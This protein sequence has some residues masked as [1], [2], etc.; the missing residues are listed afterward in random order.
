MV[1]VV[2]F[3]IY[4][5][6]V[7]LHI[8]L[9]SFEMICTVVLCALKSKLISFTSTYILRTHGSELDPTWTR[10]M[11]RH[12]WL[13]VCLASG[14]LKQHKAAK[15]KGG[16]GWTFTARAVRTHLSCCVVA[17]VSEL[18]CV[19]VRERER[20]RLCREP[21]EGMRT[22]KKEEREIG[23]AIYMP[24]Y[25]VNVKLLTSL[26]LFFVSFDLFMELILLL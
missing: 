20:E 18:M 19:C 8:I 25:Y 21:K 4:L 12:W 2:F 5:L 11:R 15:W 7:L 17:S 3:C 6:H 23:S 22:W 13:S 24:K 10:T 1:V 16:G 14:R 9:K 26:L